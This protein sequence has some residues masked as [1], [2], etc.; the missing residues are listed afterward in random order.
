MADLKRLANLSQREDWLW[1]A[2]AGVCAALLLL[3]LQLRNVILPAAA[4]LPIAV[5][6]ILG[7]ATR[8]TWPPVVILIWT[9]VLQVRLEGH[10]AGVIPAYGDASLY[11]IA[12]G[13]CAL[14]YIAAF[15]RYLTCKASPESE[16]PKFDPLTWAASLAAWPVVGMMLWSLL[17]ADRDAM[18]SMQVSADV[19]LLL[20][21]A[22]LFGGL[23]IVV[24]AI[25]TTVDFHTMTTSESRAY[26]SDTIYHD[27]RSDLN[28]IAGKQSRNEES[29]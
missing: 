12:V 22:W 18:E 27:L 26:L 21:A 9:T 10:P 28:R 4:V 17:P 19:I 5:F 11:D 6:A 14:G 23:A 29:E 2:L 8:W 24:R 1:G 25:V 3:S 15:Y 13:F 16:R 20:A 7:L